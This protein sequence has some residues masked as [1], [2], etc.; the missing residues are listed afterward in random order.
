MQKKEKSASE[1]ERKSA[2]LNPSKDRQSWAVELGTE[3]RGT[4]AQGGLC[5]PPPPP[6]PTPVCS[7]ARYSKETTCTAGE[8]KSRLRWNSRVGSSSP[9]LPCKGAASQYSNEN[10]ES[11]SSRGYTR[12]GK[13]SKHAGLNVL[14]EGHGIRYQM[15]REQKIQTHE[16]PHGP[17]AEEHMSE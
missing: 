3:D 1:W 7:R 11:A 5:T 17:G 9:P 8:I 12:V 15:G 14:T 2:E 10:T 16:P 6:P 13:H 4:A